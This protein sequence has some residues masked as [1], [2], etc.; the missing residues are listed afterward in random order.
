MGASRGENAMNDLLQGRYGDPGATCAICD[1]TVRALPGRL[2]P[3]GGFRS[4]SSISIYILC[5]FCV[6][7]PGA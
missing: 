1:P 3:L 4:K 2:S 6:G 7:A 5:R